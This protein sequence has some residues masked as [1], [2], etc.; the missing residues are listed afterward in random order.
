MQPS[1]TRND[2]VKELGVEGLPQ[3]TQDE[4]I[5]RVS[6]AILKHIFVEIL[7]QMPDE[8]QTSF[9]LL[10]DAGKGTEAEALAGQHIPDLPAFI[11]AETRKALDEFKNTPASA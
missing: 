10:V 1:Y 7:A 11:A 9:K 5:A 8:A 3:A 6:T 2:L 4:I